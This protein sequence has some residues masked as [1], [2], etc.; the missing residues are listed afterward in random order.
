MTEEKAG[1]EM[2]LDAARFGE[3][4]ELIQL[5]D[6]GANI[7]ERGPGG[8]SAL[9]MAAA[10]GEEDV[11]RELLARGANAMAEN[12]AGNTPLHYAAQQKQLACLKLLLASHCDVLKQNSFGKSILSEALATAD[13]AVASAVLEH[14]SAAEERIIE[15]LDQ[16]GE[17]SVTHRLD[18]GAGTL[19]VRELQIASTVEGTFGQGDRTGLAMWSSALVLSRWLAES[20]FDGTAL[21]LGCGCGLVGL[22]LALAAPSLTRIVLTDSCKDAL[23]NAAFNVAAFLGEES[24]PIADNVTSDATRRIS[25]AQLDWNEPPDNI[26]FDRAVGA[27]LVYCQEA[28]NALAVTIAATTH[29]FWY[30]APTTGRAGADLLVTVLTTDFGFEHSVENA[31]P[32]FYASPFVSQDNDA[33]LL[34]FPDMSANTFQLHR[35]R[36]TPPR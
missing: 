36:R 17:S 34:Y 33:F 12:E 15:G 3:L 2:M 23:R 13:G 35:F 30:V 20:Q 31:P 1:F 11:V 8:N 5:L 16:K 32:R 6:E 24:V 19:A 29:D 14:A 28:A 18:L 27:D 10:N 22:A 9:H 4:P 25:V 21:E 7:E 26:L